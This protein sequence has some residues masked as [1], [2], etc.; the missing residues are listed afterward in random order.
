MIVMGHILLLLGLATALVGQA[1][2][3]V[4]AFKRSL[5]WFFGC[6]FLPLADVMFLC[7]NFRATARPLG[8]AVLGLLVA[9]LGANLAGL[10]L[11]G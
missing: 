9:G 3:L 4:V 8:V 7:L 5:W 2:F 10:D 1:M 11:P 6:M